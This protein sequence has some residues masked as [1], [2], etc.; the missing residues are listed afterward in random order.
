MTAFFSWR[1]SRPLARSNFMR[2]PFLRLSLK[3]CLYLGSWESC[4]TSD[5]SS[6][7]VAKRYVPSKCKVNA[8]TPQ[9]NLLPLYRRRIMWGISVFHAYGHQW[10]CQL[11]Y[12]PRKRSG[13]GFSDGEGCERFWSAISS[14]VAPLRVSNVSS[15]PPPFTSYSPCP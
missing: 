8:D 15:L 14:L 1:I 11:T 10:P 9:Y 5:A 13:F 7:G 4:T 3:S 6:T 2:W 12:H